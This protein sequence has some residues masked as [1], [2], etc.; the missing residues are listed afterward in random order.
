M[1][2]TIYDGVVEPLVGGIT[3]WVFF[4]QPATKMS[5]LGALLMVVAFAFAGIFSGKHF[6]RKGLKI[7]DSFVR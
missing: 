7:L 4:A 1:S 3:A 2:A 5:V 6:L